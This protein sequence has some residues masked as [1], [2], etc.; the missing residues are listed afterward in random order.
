MGIT[1]DQHDGC[2]HE[3]DPETGMNKCYLV[4]P[5]G[6]RKDL[7][8]PVRRSYIHL[9]CGTRTTMGQAIAE[10]YAANPSFYGATFC[11]N[12]RGH[13]PVGEQGEFVWDGSSRK[14]GT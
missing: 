9:T 1:T 10:T 8:R 7:V 3:V 11:V 13:F 6:Q 4:L 2:L 5:D 12:C 14:V